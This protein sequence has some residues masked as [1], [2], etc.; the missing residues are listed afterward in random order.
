M[1]TVQIKKHVCKE[2]FH[3]KKKKII[4]L[5]IDTE[6]RQFL[7]LFRRH[8]PFFFPRIAV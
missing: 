3:K 2:I 8:R 4:Y 7:R 1:L 6:G 5:C